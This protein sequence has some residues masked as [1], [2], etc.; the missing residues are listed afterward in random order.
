ML[1]LLVTLRIIAKLAV[2]K[3]DAWFIAHR[4]GVVAS[5]KRE[6]IAGAD[7]AASAVVGNNLHPSGDHIAQVLDLA[8]L[9]ACDRLDVVAP[10]PTRFE[11]A[12]TDNA[13][14]DVENLGVS[15]PFEGTLLVG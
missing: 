11:D 7:L 6:D 5:R 10:L 4:F 12:P 15:L 13:A 1:Y 2:V 8:G 3:G 14:T 9:G